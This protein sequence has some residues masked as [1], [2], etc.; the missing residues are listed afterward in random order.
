MITQVSDRFIVN[1]DVPEIIPFEPGDE[2]SMLIEM[3]GKIR[4]EDTQ[5]FII[6]QSQYFSKPT[7][8]DFLKNVLDGYNIDTQYVDITSTD[9]L[10]TKNW[11]LTMVLA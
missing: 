3:N 7:I 5:N 9:F 8:R 6:E 10:V 2:L 11:K 4:V 1:D